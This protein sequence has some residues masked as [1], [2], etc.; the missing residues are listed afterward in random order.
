MDGSVVLSIREDGPEAGLN[1][2]HLSPD[3]LN[4]P[5]SIFPSTT[6]QS[7]TQLAIYSVNMRID[8]L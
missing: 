2:L 1:E 3:Q 7:I 8:D 4:G 6:T 5:Y